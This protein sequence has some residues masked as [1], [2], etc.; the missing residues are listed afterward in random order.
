[1]E[2]QKAVAGCKL[3]PLVPKGTKVADVQKRNWIIGKPIGAGAFGAIYLARREKGGAEDDYVV[4]VEPHN[5]GPLWC[6]MHAL[7]RFG[8]ESHRVN[9]KPKNGKPQGWVGIPCLYGFG[10]F[11]LGEEKLRFVMMSRLGSDIEKFFQSGRKPLPLTTALNISIQI[12]ESLEYIHGKNYTH[13][14]IKAQNVLLGHGQDQHTVYLVDFGLACKYRD[15]YGFHKDSEPDER[16]AHEGT[17]EYTSRDAHNGTHSRRGDLESL[18]YNLVHWVTGY[19][20]WTVSDDPEYVQ[21][22]KIGFMFN[23]PGF[24]KRC[25]KPQAHPKVL[26]DYLVYTN[27]LE[28]DEAPDYS[29]LRK[30][31]SQAMTKEGVAPY[32]ELVFGSRVREEREESSDEEDFGQEETRNT[33]SQDGDE[34]FAP[35]SWE[36]V[37]CQ[38]PESIIRQASR[39]SDATDSEDPVKAAAFEQLQEET[40]TNP[41]PEM[42]KLLA[43]KEQ[44]E[45]A[46]Q[47]LSWKDQLS[48]YNNR[49]TALKA[50]FVSMDLTPSELT[51]AMEEVIARR[52]ERLAS[53][54]C[55]PMTPEP[56]DDELDVL[57]ETVRT[58]L[59]AN[60]TRPR[61][62][63]SESS[64]SGTTTPRSTRQTS[65]TPGSRQTS[66]TPGSRQTSATPGSRTGS[67]GPSRPGSSLSSTNPGTSTPRSSTSTPV[68][69]ERITRSRASSRA[70]SPEHNMSA[71]STRSTRS[72]ASSPDC[73]AQ[74]TSEGTRP[75]TR[76]SKAEESG[77][78]KTRSKGPQ[79]GHVRP[80]AAEEEAEF[81]L[82][83]I[84]TSQAT[85]DVCGKRMTKKS[86]Q[87]HT[88][89]FHPTAEMEIDPLNPGKREPASPHTPVI[90]QK[91]VRAD[92]HNTPVNEQTRVWAD[93]HNTP[94]NE[95]TRIQ[96]NTPLPNQE[97]EITRKI[98]LPSSND[99]IPQNNANDD[100]LLED[101]PHCFIRLPRL[102][103][104][105]HF[106]YIHSPYRKLTRMMAL[107]SPGLPVH[108][109]SLS[110]LKIRNMTSPEKKGTEAEKENQPGISAAEAVKMRRGLKF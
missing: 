26:E 64:V 83:Q 107:P 70:S 58:V 65:A 5:N 50:K 24:L 1:M 85:C 59:R 3:A 32:S 96:H 105:E 61:R 60:K 87:R 7:L 77:V 27:S 20:P 56:S 4:K 42:K 37:L 13:N 57:E 45:M 95:Q 2:G 89:N 25:F 18:G 49:T 54:V 22:Q 99:D 12:L 9:W 73:G 21:S 43:A 84:N 109:S 8:L 75:K 36:Q 78:R 110:P 28:F 94:V 79:I 98:P 15:N 69:G 74:P 68:F 41:T 100:P 11:N 71:R 67:P 52:A 76:A 17:L 106:D 19:L 10:S 48:E 46:R 40:L 14:D 39:S 97:Q 88:E 6:E 29:K 72:S 47:K 55:S 51:P 30:L 33:R 66:A 82:P 86:L 31:L 53:G 91:R 103:I 101:C 63:K 81:K 44:L 93:R 104:A 108:V 35:W 62:N 102:K 80:K 90:R 23:V 16:K 38:D 92:R 34:R